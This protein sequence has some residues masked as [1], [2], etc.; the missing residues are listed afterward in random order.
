MAQ[1]GS[2]K[3]MFDDVGHWFERFLQPGALVELGVVA[4]CVPDVAWPE[5]RG[6]VDALPL[7]APPGETASDAE[8]AGMLPDPA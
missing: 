3:P 1:G 8:D 7:T 5:A 2:D 4:V 6:I